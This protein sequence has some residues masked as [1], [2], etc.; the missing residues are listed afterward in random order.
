MALHDL[1]PV[2]VSDLISHH[3]AP[4]KL[5]FFRRFKPP[6]L[7]LALA[8]GPAVASNWKTLSPNLCVTFFLV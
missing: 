2:S 5:A 8:F 3:S 6:E 1:T 4:F 7:S